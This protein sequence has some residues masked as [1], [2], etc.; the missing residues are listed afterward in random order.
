MPR[1]DSGGVMKNRYIAG[2][3]P[4]DS[5]TGTSLGN[6]W[7]F[8]TFHQWFVAEYTGRPKFADDFYEICRR[9]LLFYDARAN[10]EN[11]LKGLFTYFTQKNSTYLLCDTPSFLYDKE[12]VKKGGYGNTLKGTRATPE[13]NAYA[14]RLLRDWL[15]TDAHQIFQEYDD[16]YNIINKKLNMHTIKSIPFL[17]ELTVWNGDLN[18][19]RVSGTVS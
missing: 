15:L 6:I 2:I 3:D 1:K 8:D 19:D 5:D 16:D 17:E 11:N 13:V 9:L 14:R 7:I 12:L 18:C 4:I 10:Y